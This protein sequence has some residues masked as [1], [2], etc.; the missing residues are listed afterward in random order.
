[1]ADLFGLDIAGIVNDAIT[2]AGGVRPGT[3]TKTTPGTRTPGDLTG[4]TNPT[5]TTHTFQGFID[6][7]AERRKLQIGS[8][9]EARA[10]SIL[11]A[12]VSPE[13]IPEVNDTVEMDG[14]T[15]M[16]VSLIGRD[17]AEALYEFDAQAI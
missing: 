2:Q 1:M 15:Y 10:V 5:T 7:K 17:P 13:A 8:T 6:Q 12:S 16:L 11:G 9:L 4:G 14:N 3:L